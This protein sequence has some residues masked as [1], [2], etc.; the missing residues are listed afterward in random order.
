MA[1]DDAVIIKDNHIKTVG[2][3]A[4]ALKRAK[5]V[6]F[7]KK[8]EVEAQ[9]LEEAVEAAEGGADIIMIDNMSPDRARETAKSIR[10][11]DPK[12]TIE[13]SGG[14]NPDNAIDYAAIG[15]VI[16]LG[17]ITHSVR[18]IDFSLNVA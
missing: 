15:D 5:R 16:S 4:K 7:S 17:W 3:V 1:L 6:S 10:G 12:I 2:G 8:V 11:I 13:I 9:T 18:S 14:I